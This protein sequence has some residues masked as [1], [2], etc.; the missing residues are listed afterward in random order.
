MEINRRFIKPK[1]NKEIFWMTYSKN[2]LS[3]GSKALC[4]TICKIYRLI[5]Q[6]HKYYG[7][8]KWTMMRKHAFSPR[9]RCAKNS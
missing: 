9:I 4:N 6:P 8:N 3:R 7:G 1:L 2:S 5:M